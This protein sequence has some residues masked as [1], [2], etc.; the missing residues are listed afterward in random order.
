MNRVFAS[1]VRPF[2][3]L[4]AKPEVF[5]LEVNASLRAYLEACWRAVQRLA[6]EF[7][8][9]FDSAVFLC[10]GVWSDDA[11]LAE[12]LLAQNEYLWL[13]GLPQIRNMDELQG[14]FLKIYANGEVVFCAYTDFNGQVFESAIVTIDELISDFALQ[15]DSSIGLRNE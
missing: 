13:S 7:G 2:D 5:V 3:I 11:S 10:Q 1:S 12:A 15:Q 8:V 9:K 4:F 14:Q 6:S